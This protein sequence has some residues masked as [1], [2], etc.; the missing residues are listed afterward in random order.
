MS[1]TRYTVHTSAVRQDN[2]MTTTSTDAL[3]DWDA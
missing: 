3:R 2:G 1:T